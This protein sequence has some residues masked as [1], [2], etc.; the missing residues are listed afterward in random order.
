MFKDQYL[1]TLLTLFGPGRFDLLWVPGGA[2]QAPLT[3]FC[4]GENFGTPKIEI[5]LYLFLLA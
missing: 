1:K 4:F 5:L 2:W 3:L